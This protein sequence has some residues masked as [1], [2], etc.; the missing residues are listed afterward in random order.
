LANATKSAVSAAVKIEQTT[1]RRAK[2]ALFEDL[3]VHGC[4]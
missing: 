4:F 3:D 2:K 1:R